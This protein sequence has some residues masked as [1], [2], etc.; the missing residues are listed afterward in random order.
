MG[1]LKGRGEKMGKRFF[2]NKMAVILFFIFLS[3][4]AYGQF[5]TFE[6]NNTMDQ[7]TI[8]N[9]GGEVNYVRFWGTSYDTDNDLSQPTHADI[10]P[11]TDLDWYKL[12]ADGGDTLV[13]EMRMLAPKTMDGVMKLY[14]RKRLLIEA[15]WSGAGQTEWLR[16]SI[17]PDSGG[18]YYICAYSLA[19]S[20]TGRYRLLI[21]KI[22][23]RTTVIKNALSKT[24]DFSLFQNYPNPFNPKTRIDFSLKNRS[25]VVLK[26]FNSLGKEI[27]TLGDGWFESGLNS[28]DFNADRLP[29][30]L[31]FYRMDTGGTVEVKKMMILK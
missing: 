7:A 11:A 5:D 23:S 4:Q 15:Q 16:W 8:V 17:P 3:M 27:M 10:Y 2:F 21:S 1:T 26:V 12:Q 28:V 13:N 24:P 18:T 6:P 29:A 19:N 20:Q 31:Y 9:F 14:Y 25:H 30:G 22:R